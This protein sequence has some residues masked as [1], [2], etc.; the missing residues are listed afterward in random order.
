MNVLQ[1]SRPHK[2]EIPTWSKK[3]KFKIYQLKEIYELEEK[4]LK[5]K[6]S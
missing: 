6:R 2:E 1:K 5:L 4:Q 3:L